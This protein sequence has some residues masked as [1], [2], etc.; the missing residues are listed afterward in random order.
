MGG[1]SSINGQ[2]W[3]RP[4]KQFLQQLFLASGEDADWRPSHV[5]DMLK[6]MTRKWRAGQQPKPPS[7]H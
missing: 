1:S 3:V 5:Y 2:Q 4:S 7:I 6:V